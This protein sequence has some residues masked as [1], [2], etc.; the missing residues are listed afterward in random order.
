M[1]QRSNEEVVRAYVKA[2]E[3]GDLDGAGA[4]RHKDFVGEW[5]QSGE[6]IR[7]EA[8]MRALI[9][10]YPGGAPAVHGGRLIGSEDRWVVTPVYSVQRIVGSGDSWWGDGTITYPDGSTWNY[11]IFVEIRDGLVYRETEYFA[12]PFEA[13]EWRRPFVEKMDQGDAPG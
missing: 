11:A 4:L 7:G 1:T 6:R 9:E 10:N 3:T 8:N 12:A 2:M 13:P 5:P